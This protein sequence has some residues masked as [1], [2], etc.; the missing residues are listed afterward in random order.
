MAGRSRT[1]LL[2]K[3]FNCTGKVWPSKF[4]EPAVLQIDRLNQC[5]RSH[6]PFQERIM[7]F[8]N[9]H[10]TDESS[11]YTDWGWS[12][13]VW[14]GFFF[15]YFLRVLIDP[16]HLPLSPVPSMSRLCSSLN[17]MT[18]HNIVDMY[19]VHNG[20]IIFIRKFPHLKFLLELNVLAVPFLILHFRIEHCNCPFREHFTCY[21]IY[22][23]Q[24][25]R[26]A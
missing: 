10:C 9:F 4:K 11:R 6:C 13:L 18:E 20:H 1:S 5:G 22:K 3:R 19:E 12:G 16:S 26:E 17:S 21:K 7:G 15:L 24:N 23:T 14:E 25:I 2:T 8:I